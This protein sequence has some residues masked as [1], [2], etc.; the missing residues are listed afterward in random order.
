VVLGF[1]T[2]VAYTTILCPGTEL[3]VNLAFCPTAVVVAVTVGPSIAIDPSKSA[4]GARVTLPPPA[5]GSTPRVYV[6]ELGIYMG[7][8]REL[9]FVQDVWPIT[10]L[11]GPIK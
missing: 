4:D 10:V 8:R 2:F 3:K 11:V 1:V 7:L 5:P 9:E 6:L